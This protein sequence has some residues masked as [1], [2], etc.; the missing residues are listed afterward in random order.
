MRILCQKHLSFE[1][2][3]ELVDWALTSRHPLRSNPVYEYGV[4]PSIKDFGCP[5]VIGGPMDIH[6]DAKYTWLTP[7]KM[8]SREAIVRSKYVIGIY[9]IGNYLYD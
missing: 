8:L 9:L 3:T 1:A 4:L 5:F 2:H 6:E 7:E